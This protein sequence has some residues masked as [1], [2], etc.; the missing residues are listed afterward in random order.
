MSVVISPLPHLR[1]CGDPA[2]GGAPGG[3][4]PHR[5]HLPRHRRHLPRRLPPHGLR[6]GAA[7]RLR[8][9]RRHVGAEGR[10]YGVLALSALYFASTG[11]S[12]RL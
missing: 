7:V 10:N 1:S 3:Q 4:A 11:R 9:L 8:P 2:G 12:G 6:R 5:V